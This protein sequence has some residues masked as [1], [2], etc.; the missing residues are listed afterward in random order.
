[1]RNDIQRA[2]S[3]APVAAP[4]H[5]TE[6]YTTGTRRMSPGHPGGGRDRAIPPYRYGEDAGAAATTASRPGAGPGPGSWSAVIVLLLIGG[7]IFAFK[8]VSG[9]GGSISVP[10]VTN[11][12]LGKAEAAIKKAK[13]DVARPIKYAKSATVKR[14]LVISTSPSA[15]TS[16]ASGTKV[17][18]VVSS[19][20]GKI[21]VPSVM[22]DS[23]AQAQNA[24]G[25][26]GLTVVVNTRYSLR[27]P[28]HVLS[29]SPIAGTHV[30]AGAPVS[31]WVARRVRRC[32]R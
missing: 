1:M 17:K 9:N 18:V 19:G 11:E 16:V 7:G 15:G 22:G 24:L 29:Q 23:Q 27:Q 5:H 4:M 6:M 20:V 3:G 32:P 13:L 21:K 8:F 12:T 25:R 31:I 26:A 10:G 2:L 30:K 14:G 28:G